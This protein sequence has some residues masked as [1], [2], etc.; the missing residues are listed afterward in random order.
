MGTK[1]RGQ[2]CSHKRG[3]NWGQNPIILLQRNSQA[4]EKIKKPIKKKIF[5]YKIINQIYK[6]KIKELDILC[7][8]WNLLTT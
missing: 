8:E 3:Q 4:S 6:D 5:Y 7:I 1:F 2:I